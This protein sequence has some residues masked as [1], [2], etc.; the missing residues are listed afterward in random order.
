[1]AE[2]NSEAHDEAVVIA[3]LPE[4]TNGPLGSHNGSEKP[5]ALVRISALDK[6]FEA[7]G[8]ATVKVGKQTLTLPIQ[9]VDLEQVEALVRPYRPK[10]PVRRE[11]INGTWTDVVNQA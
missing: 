4:A 7:R 10:V 8:E 11:R 3:G 1:M 5:K 6:L 9:S 2:Y